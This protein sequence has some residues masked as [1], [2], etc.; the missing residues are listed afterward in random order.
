MAK[1]SVELAMHRDIAQ[2]SVPASYELTE[3]YHGPNI[4]DLRFSAS[5]SCT[6]HVIAINREVYK[7]LFEYEKGDVKVER[8]SPLTDGDKV[9]FVVSSK[10]A[11]GIWLTIKGSYEDPTLVEPSQDEKDG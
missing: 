9:T 3:V 1:S 8:D 10:D 5:R 11:G 7:G 4:D 6:V 2:Q